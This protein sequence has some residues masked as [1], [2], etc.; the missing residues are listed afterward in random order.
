MANNVTLPAAGVGDTTPVVETVQQT[1]SGNPH[2]QIFAS[3]EVTITQTITRPANT[4]TYTIGDALMD[5]AATSGG[6]TLTGI[7]SISGGSGRITDVIFVFDEDAATP[8]QGEYLLFDTA[9]T[10]PGD[11]AAFVVSDAEIRTLVGVVPFALTD[12]GNNGSYHAQG[13]SI[14]FTT[15][16]SANLRTAI[17]V[18]N[19]Y[20]PTTNSSVLTIRVKAIL[21]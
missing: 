3:K 16:G 10:N 19:A 21:G 12:R 17:R 18:L 6:D 13:L 5:T 1:S 15:V 9:F 2:R 11:N 8:L 14:G 20:V 4:T 7:A